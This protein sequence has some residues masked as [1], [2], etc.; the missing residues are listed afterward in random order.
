MAL[1]S[2]SKEN[3][4][5]FTDCYH[6]TYADSA[7]SCHTTTSLKSLDNGTVQKANRTL[8]GAVLTLT[9][10]GRKT[11]HTNQGVVRVRVR[12]RVRN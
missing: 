8:V 12:I 7:C 3:N 1:A 2:G 6:P 5:T 10:K 9:H 4:K 11:I